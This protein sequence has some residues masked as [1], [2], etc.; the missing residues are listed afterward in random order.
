MREMTRL[1]HEFL[2]KYR[3]TYVLDITKRNRFAP[4]KNEKGESDLSKRALFS[5][6]P[7]TMV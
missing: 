4:I 5:P 6:D 2:I 7:I 1:E 3:A